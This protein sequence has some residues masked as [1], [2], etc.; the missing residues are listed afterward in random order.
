MPKIPKLVN[1]GPAGLLS[2]LPAGLAPAAATDGSQVVAEERKLNYI[3]KSLADLT[4]SISKLVPD[5]NNARVHP[6]RNLEAIKA[7]LLLYGQVKPLVVRRATNVVI[8]G[9]GTLEAAKLLGWTKL[10]VN[11]VD[12]NEV[13]AAGYGLADN[14]SAELA[15]WDFEVVA[16]LV[17]L[18]E[19]AKVNPV[20]WTA[21]EL[22]VLRTQD[23][24]APTEEP[25]APLNLSERFIVPPFSVLDARQGYW[26]SRKRSWLALGIKSEL[27]RG[28]T[29]STSA[30]VGPEDEATYSPIGGRKKDDN[31]LLGFS[32]QARSHYKKSNATPGGSLLPAATL[33]KDGKT[34]RGDGKGRP[35]A[36]TFVSGSPR[37]LA[38]DMKARKESTLGAVPPNERSSMDRSGQS[39]TSI[40]DPVLCELV[41]RWFTPPTGHIFDP[42]AGGSV[43]G[44]VAAKLGRQYT[45]IDLRPEQAEANR[46]QAEVIVPKAKLRWVV[47]DACDTLQLVKKKQIDKSF[48]LVFSCPPYADLE[49]YS[50]DPRDLST[51]G[52]EA[53]LESYRLIIADSC[54]LLKDNRFACFV[55]GDIRD[56]KTG[57]YRNFIGDTVDAFEAA[58]LS[59][60]NEAI[61]VTAVGSLPIR[62]GRQF[63]SYR[64][65]GKTHQ[66]VLVFIKGDAGK[67]VKDCGPVEILDLNELLKEVT[68][69]G[70]A[71]E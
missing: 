39:G 34:V 62:V 26:Q 55:V 54:S 8:A 45:G 69:V 37:D 13:E 36:R 30:R 63:S 32:E 27:G 28:D 52:Y 38:A 66:Q 61:L 15:G 29:G 19:E 43:R 67:A 58:G 11:Y 42:F 65:L 41:Y 18:Q 14:R 3:A 21:E 50:D 10:A 20:G 16:R 46:V 51:M 64:K 70:V 6:E 24:S 48:D 12:M 47:G 7:S 53:F 71:D 17:K 35:L 40:F 44:I 1:R 59:L 25:A 23:W 2:K 56:R 5:P 31:G 57:S 49:R 60:Y 9:N 68:D 33:G 4:V 22:I